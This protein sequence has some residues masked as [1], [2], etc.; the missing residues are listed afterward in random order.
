MSSLSLGTSKVW[1][2]RGDL[3][4]EWS[5]ILMELR[6]QTVS[7]LRQSVENV[8]ETIFMGEPSFLQ[9]HRA[10]D[11]EDRYGGCPGYWWESSWAQRQ[12]GVEI[13]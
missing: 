12:S 7:K 6:G 5:D 3:G 8:K 13:V 10:G 11:S 2:Y 1:G 9:T 4:Q